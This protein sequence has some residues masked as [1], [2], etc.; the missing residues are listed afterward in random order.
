MNNKE[1]TKIAK[2]VVKIITSSKATFFVKDEKVKIP[3][4][5]VLC[6]LQA[7]ICTDTEFYFCELLD[8]A[9]LKEDE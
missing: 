8:K 4:E 1:L 6:E 2:D 9:K 7:Q 3:P 5:E